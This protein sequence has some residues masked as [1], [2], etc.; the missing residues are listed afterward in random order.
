MQPCL[1]ELLSDSLLASSQSLAFSSFAQILVKAAMSSSSSGPCEILFHRLL[2]GPLDR[3]GIHAS[4]LGKADQRDPSIALVGATLEMAGVDLFLHQPRRS[5]RADA[6]KLTC[7]GAHRL[8]LRLLEPAKDLAGAEGDAMAL[9][10][11][12]IDT[13]GHGGVGEQQGPPPVHLV[14]R[15]EQR[16]GRG[17]F[18][19]CSISVS[20]ADTVA[21]WRTHLL[22]WSCEPLT[23]SA[24]GGPHTIGGFFS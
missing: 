10:Q 12:G 8:R 16:L 19:G 9:H 14:V 18:H 1:G 6:D 11:H 24:D 21:C 15:D 3:F 4:A 7:Q 13:G 17:R 2:Q 23:P 20:R 5:R 22:V